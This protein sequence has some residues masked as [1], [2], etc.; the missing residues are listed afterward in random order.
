MSDRGTPRNSLIEFNVSHA[1][2]KKA[3]LTRLAVRRPDGR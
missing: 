3:S 2:K 1:D